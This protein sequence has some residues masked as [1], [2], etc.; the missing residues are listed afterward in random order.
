MEMKDKLMYAAYIGYQ[1]RAEFPNNENV[2]NELDFIFNNINIMRKVAEIVEKREFKKNADGL[3][4]AEEFYEEGYNDAVKL[5][6]DTVL[7]KENK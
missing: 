4:D 1:L 7:R 5:F 2:I 6:D 3:M